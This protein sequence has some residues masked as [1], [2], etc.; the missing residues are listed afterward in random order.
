MSADR[1]NHRPEVPFSLDEFV[2]RHGPRRE[3]MLPL[4]KEVAAEM[5]AQAKV[6]AEP[7]EAR[8]TLAAAV[9]PRLSRRLPGAETITLGLCTL[10]P[11]LEQRAAAL[12]RDNPLAAM[13]LTQIGSLW[14]DG[15]MRAVHAEIRAEARARGRRA[16]PPYRPGLGRWPLE[17]QDEIFQ[18]LPA[19]ALGVSLTEAWAMMPQKSVSFIVAEGRRLGP[20]RFDGG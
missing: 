5:M 4:F 19:A 15:L 6:L 13:V 20:S 1:I 9:V 8:A 3:R 7:R 18:H 16:G 17:F 11:A 2:R 12:F 14:V 10:G